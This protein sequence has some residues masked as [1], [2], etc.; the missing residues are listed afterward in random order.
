[1]R[2]LCVLGSVVFVFVCA[3]GSGNGAPKPATAV[4]GATDPGA[5]PAAAEAQGPATAAI[6]LDDV[7][8][9][10][11]EGPAAEAATRFRLEDWSAAR[12]GFAAFLK[13]H[14]TGL[15]A[16]TRARATLLLALSEAELGNWDQAAAGL[17]AVIP[18]LPLLADYLRYQAARAR[19]FAHDMN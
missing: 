8:P 13:A 18:E 14:G 7:R 12:D 5:E 11:D 2:H 10:F 3:C 16:G 17:E 1:M 4:P 19:Y 6:N 9:Y 15:D